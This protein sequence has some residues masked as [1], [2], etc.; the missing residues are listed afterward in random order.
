MP[1]PADR[2][3]TDQR[4]RWEA[5]ERVPVE[6]YLAA[7]PELLPETV[8]DLIYQEAVLREEG[9]ERVRADDYVRR[10]PAHATAIARQF[11]L[12]ALVF[13]PA[14]GVPPAAD[15]GANPRVPSVPG[16]RLTREIGSGS[17]GVVYEAVQLAVGRAVAVKL[18]RQ[19]AGGRDAA[20]LL[21]REAATVA[22]ID[23]PNVV[24]VYDAGEADGRAYMAM[25]VV[26]GGTL[27]DRL[28]S[29]PLP[30]A[31]AANLA[32]Q[33]AHGVAAAHAAAVVHRDLKPHNILLDG[34]TPKVADFG[35]AKLADVPSTLAGSGVL[36]GTAPYM[37]PEQASGHTRA[38]GPAT[39]V[40]ALGVLLHEMEFPTTC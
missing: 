32:R 36:L 6:V 24:R 14:A 9:G 34:G 30:W 17:W 11:E 27:D 33:I 28:R 37:A 22:R 31:K 5:G 4:T 18:S 25:E 19:P 23:H 16:Y 40:F 1:N 26:R 8:L 39:D 7:A 21:V 38:V 12:H 15:A 2:L 20:A 29:G 10:F 35:L 13:P 3:R